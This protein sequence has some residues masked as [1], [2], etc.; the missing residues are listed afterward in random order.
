M[1]YVVLAYLLL[2]RG[3]GGHRKTNIGLGRYGRGDCVWNRSTSGISP[4]ERVNANVQVSRVRGLNRD[5]YTFSKVDQR[6]YFTSCRDTAYTAF[7]L[8]LHAR[9][10]LTSTTR[11]QCWRSNHDA[12]LQI[13]FN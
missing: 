6:D 7:I 4:L 3:A 9:T 12:D 5:I 13:I 1:Q 10:V 11:C 8:G 2:K